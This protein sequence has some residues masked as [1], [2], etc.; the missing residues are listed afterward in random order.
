MFAHARLCCAE[1]PAPGGWIFAVRRLQR[2]LN[3]PD[4]QPDSCSSTG[5]LKRSLAKYRAEV[6][7]P[8]VATSCGVLPM[9]PPLPWAWIGANANVHFKRES[10]SLW[11]QLRAL[12]QAYPEAS[13][14]WCDGGPDLT[15]EH[16]RFS[17]LTFAARGVLPE[18]AFDYPRNDGW[19]IAVLLAV[20]DIIVS[21]HTKPL[22]SIS[23][24]CPWSK[25]EV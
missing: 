3:I 18:Q 19:F 22:H 15:R 14:S 2:Q 8:A 13:C 16:L 21:I 9:N 1:D 17:C 20:E 24:R 12:G 25:M 23:C 4:W 10:F 7:Q 5:S 11:W 6:V